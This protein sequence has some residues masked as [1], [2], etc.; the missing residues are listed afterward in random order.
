METQ[1]R[2]M[3]AGVP[4][5]TVR[6]KPHRPKPNTQ[7]DKVLSFIQNRGSI[8]S[9]EAVQH[10]RVFRLAAVVFELRAL[11]WP[12]VTITEPHD[13]GTHA[14]YKLREVASG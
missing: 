14:R 1:Q 10:L 2:D 7:L 6:P 9:L 4:G 11:N 13:G 8:S 5:I 3:F 12:I